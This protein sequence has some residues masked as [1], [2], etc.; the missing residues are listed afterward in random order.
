[1]KIFL[2]FV[3]HVA[4]LF[5]LIVGFVHAQGC[6]GV[7]KY[8]L[9]S[10]MGIDKEL[11]PFMGLEIA[12]CTNIPLFDG[13][14]GFVLNEQNEKVNNGIRSE[15]AIGFPF[16]E[17]DTVEYRWSINVPAKDAPGGDANQWWAIAQWHDQPDL[18]RGETWATFKSQPPPVSVYMEKRNGTVGI[19]L[20]GWMS[21]KL[22]WKPLPTD[23]WL[24]LRV[25]IHWSTSS[26]GSVIFRVDGHPELDFVSA[27]RNMI[28]SYQHY[29]KAGQYRDPTV[30]KYSVIYMK[31][32]HFRKL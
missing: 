27:G 21:K 9:A 7:D 19:G 6:K 10:V 17:G 5:F 25:V 15:M 22:S 12:D 20:Q 23:V 31:N 13:Y 11:I 1:M 16:A 18:R 26:N 4:F 32:V 14:A 8:K 3:C 28:N 24:D 30:H 29:F 2:R